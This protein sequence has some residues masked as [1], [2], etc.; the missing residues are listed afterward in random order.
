[1]GRQI[2]VAAFEAVIFDLD[3]TLIDSEHW[4][5]RA[6]IETFL[7]LGYE[8]DERDLTP[9]VGTT[10]PDMLRGLAPEVTVERFLGVEIPILATY[11]RRDMEVFSDAIRL[12]RSVASR[13]A[14]ATSSM[15]WYVSEVL[16]RFTEIAELFP[17]R[18]CQSDVVRGKPDPE[19]FLMACDRLNVAPNSAL[20]VEDSHNGVLAARSA[21]CT[22][23]AIDRTGLLDLSEADVVV[24]SLDAL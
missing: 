18:L 20:V 5:K 3:G 21:G 2:E 16:G 12:A 15:S 22:V 11:I 10:L 24:T 19:I 13:R 9:Y 17:V 23:V 1:M 7:A 6:E 14:L 4:H 8:I